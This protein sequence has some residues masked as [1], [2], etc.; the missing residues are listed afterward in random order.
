M[1]VE[2]IKNDAIGLGE[3]VR[4]GEIKPSELVEMT[5]ERI[6]YINPKLNPVIHKMYDNARRNAEKMDKEIASGKKPESKLY[7]VPFLLKDLLAEYEG[8]PFNEGSSAV[9]GYKSKDDTEL[10]RRHNAAGL[11]IIGKTNSIWYFIFIL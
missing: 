10:V 7:G 2:L 1:K 8:A 4:D 11:I 9:K 3:M 6:E 5:I